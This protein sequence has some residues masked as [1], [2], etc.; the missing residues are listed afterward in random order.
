MPGAPGRCR[1]RAHVRRIKPSHTTADGGRLLSRASVALR[2]RPHREARD[3]PGRMLGEEAVLESRDGDFVL[4][5]DSGRVP[6]IVR[7]LVGHGVELHEVRAGQRSLEDVFFE[8]TERDA[9]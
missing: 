8:L 9:T 3:V 5:A 7:H 6:E 4:R 1:Q 2:A